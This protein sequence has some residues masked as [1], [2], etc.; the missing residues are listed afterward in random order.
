MEGV[1]SSKGHIAVSYW[2][3]GKIPI[4]GTAL[5]EI[6]PMGDMLIGTWEGHTLLAGETKLQRYRGRVVM[7]HEN[8]SKIDAY[9]DG[10]PVADS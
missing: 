2:S 9:L 4:C 5:M 6:G 10:N 7:A 8:E 3:Q 1:V